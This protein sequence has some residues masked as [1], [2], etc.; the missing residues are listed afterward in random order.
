MNEFS[1]I[2]ATDVV[3][4]G[5][6]DAFRAGV[7]LS[8]RAPVRHV[9]RKPSH[10]AATPTPL[11]LLEPQQAGPIKGD[12]YRRWF[13]RVID[14]LIVA[15]SLPVLLPVLAVIM[16]MM[17]FQ[18]G[19]LFFTQKRIGRDGTIFTMLKFR[20]MVPNADRMLEEYLAKDPELRREWDADQ[21]LKKDPRITRLGGLLRRTSLDELPQIWNVVRGD[22]SVVGPRP[23]MPEQMAIY[24][25]PT[26]Y[27]SMRPGLTG[28][29]QVSE[30]NL[31]DFKSRARADTE[32]YRECTF[33]LDMKLIWR[34]FGVVLRGTGY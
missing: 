20:T 9:L 17:A 12:I 22:M 26:P 10:F 13:K 19:P 15:V 7:V 5:V 28:L 18:R 3:A 29:W 21:K 24:G 14:L 27:V 6:P 31:G 33:R 34:T 2:E 32:Y 30:R 11:R 25:D 16:G 4:A 23:M 1:K 8:E